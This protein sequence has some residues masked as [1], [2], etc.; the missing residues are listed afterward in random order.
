MSHYT[1][2]PPV[3]YPQFYPPEVQYPQL[4]PAQVP[5]PQ[6]YPYGYPVDGSGAPPLQAQ[7]DI[8]AMVKQYVSGALQ[9]A[10]DDYRK[11][12]REWFTQVNA[13][14][15]ALMEA[16]MKEV[17]AKVLMMET[18]MKATEVRPAKLPSEIDVD[19]EKR[20]DDALKKKATEVESWFYRQADIKV[21]VAEERLDGAVK[22]KIAEVGSLL[23]KQADAK[24][25]A[26]EERLDGAVKEKITK[27]ES[28]LCKQA[29]AKVSAV[30]ERL[31]SALEE[32]VAKVERWLFK[33][34]DAKVSAVEER[35][36]SALKEKA[37]GVE[38][39][40]Y[41]H[42]DAKVNAAEE[43]LD[44]ALKKVAEVESWLCKQADA[45]VSIAEE[46]LNDT[47]K[48]K[49]AEVENWLYQQADAKVSAAGERLRDSLKSD[50]EQ[51]MVV[52][53]E[54]ANEELGMR[55]YEMGLEMGR[56]TRSL[57]G[58]IEQRLNSKIGALESQ[59]VEGKETRS[60]VSEVEKRVN[61]KISALEIQINAAKDTKGAKEAHLACQKLELML[62]AQK[63]NLEARIDLLDIYFSERFDAVLGH[64]RDSGGED[65]GV[66]DKPTPNSSNMQRPEGNKCPPDDGLKM[67]ESRPTAAVKDLMDDLE[68]RLQ[69]LELRCVKLERS[70][71]KRD[72][73]SRGDGLARHYEEVPALD[74]TSPSDWVFED[75]PFPPLRHV[76]DIERLSDEQLVF[77]LQRYGCDSI[78]YSYT[79]RKRLLL[80]EI[81]SSLG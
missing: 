50:I 24:A 29:D 8:E 51:Q 32:K 53:G 19:V 71:R 37:T 5:Y 44:G 25:S 48:D 58:D 38:S 67:V 6:V 1:Y 34:S 54:K 74:G 60:L 3:P 47:L 18:G 28:W 64:L 66:N 14:Y 33:Q 39:W 27:A 12:A 42:A 49:V 76:S 31:E 30:E 41:Q 15:R 7:F 78:P 77:A 22:E 55:V 45:K 17:E 10:M 81:G 59:V 68:Q 20:L 13:Q 35:L 61:G 56:E 26:V 52:L 2:P 23:H 75:L 43:R 63:N 36:D 65:K 80:G 57:A 9:E 4:D 70:I 62:A 11:S 40:L 46:R 16:R 73:Y 79:E 69:S 72:N 21:N